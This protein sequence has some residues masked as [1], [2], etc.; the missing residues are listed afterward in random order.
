MKTGGNRK[1][2]L[3]LIFLVGCFSVV[4]VSILSGTIKPTAGELAAMGATFGGIASGMLTVMW[5]NAQ[6]HRATTGNYPPAAPT[7]PE[8]TP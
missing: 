7:K 1:F 3:G 5:G 2:I 4:L 8:G 6:E